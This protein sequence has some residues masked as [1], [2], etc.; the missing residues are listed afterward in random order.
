MLA[1]ILCC[2]QIYYTIVFIYKQKTFQ[3]VMF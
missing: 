3:L 1:K 2:V